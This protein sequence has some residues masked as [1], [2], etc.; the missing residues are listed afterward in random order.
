MK[1]KE[2]DKSIIIFTFILLKSLRCL[3]VVLLVFI[4]SSSLYSQAVNIGV[5]ITDK[6][7]EVPN[8]YVYIQKIELQILKKSKSKGFYNTN[9]DDFY[10]K[11]FD[12]VPNVKVTWNKKDGDN[13][14]YET[15]IPPLKPN[16][17]YRLKASCY[18]S[19]SIT[20]LFLM[21][22]DEKNTNWFTEDKEW[23]K[24]LKLLSDKNGDYSITYDP[25]LAEMQ[26]YKSLI[27]DIDL[28]DLDLKEA[29]YISGITDAKE[30]EKKKEELKSKKAKIINALKIAAKRVFV[31]LNFTENQDK[32][33]DQD[34]VKY[35]KWIL[36]KSEF[37]ETDV[38][39]FSTD[40]V[41][42]PDYVNV[43]NFY[44]KY[45][46]GKF[47][48][49]TIKPGKLLEEINDAVNMETETFQDGQFLPNYLGEFIPEILSNTVPI[50]TYS[51]SFKSSY[52]L[53]LVPDFGYVAYLS[54]NES[55][56]RGGNLFVG[57][58]ISLSPSNKDVPLQI[59]RLSIMQRLAIHTGVT[60]GSIEEANVR[61]N[62]F[63]NYSLLV[64]A[65]YKVLTQG[66]RVNV[67]GMFYNKLDAIN[68]SKSIAIQPYI[69]ISID[70]EIKKWLQSLFP[71]IKI[72]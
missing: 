56:P 49:Q 27:K 48:D 37:K 67:G 61:D 14:L 62:F 40:I 36:S 59:S 7:I 55:T 21:M 13:N 38:T 71:N 26:H 53:S 17:F 1:I 16:R 45:L 46:L 12:A 19:E 22:H 54:D 24:L 33:T 47:N 18:E 43:Y 50:S 15:V 8:K 4:Q 2:T 66:T 23:M 30:I 70:L 42:A 5:Q 3:L 63:G 6:E 39:Q 60:I 34:L 9:N 65:S 58:N 69:G 25:T 68:G 64:G 28:S 57:V 32:Y 10:N 29:E 31:I 20:G 41:D 72:N 52:E 44:E 11:F 35:S 51:T